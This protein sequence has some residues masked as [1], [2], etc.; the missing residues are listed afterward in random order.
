MIK[1]SAKLGFLGRKYCSC[2]VKVRSNK[3]K[4]P[5]GI[6][7]KS[8]YGSRK[9]IRTYRPSCLKK[10]DTHKCEK[11]SIGSNFIIEPSNRYVDNIYSHISPHS[12]E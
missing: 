5:Y 12:H 11:N 8:V 9:K 6:C 10:P 2:L 1:K 7:T 3:I 4:N